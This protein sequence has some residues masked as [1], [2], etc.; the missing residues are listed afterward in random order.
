MITFFISLALLVLGYFIY[1]KWVDK[2]YGSDDAHSTPAVRLKDD[3]DYVPM[4]TWKVFLI[5][6]LNIAGLGPIFGA[7]AGAMWGPVAFLWIVFGSIFIGGVHDYF[8]GMLSLRHDG[9]SLSEVLGKYLGVN[10]QMV[11][12]VVTVVLL[13]LVG[14][15][16]VKG[17]ASILDGLTEMDANIWVIII[18]IYYILATLLP[19]DKVIGKIYPAFGVVLLLMA[20]GIFISMVIK[21]VPIPELTSGNLVNMHAN[22]EQ[23][24][25][26]PMLFITIACG[27]V[28]GFHATQSPMMARCIK[29][30]SS[31][32]K[33]FFGAMITEGIVAL[34]WAAISMSFFGGVRELGETMAAQGGDAAW[35]VN[36][37]CNGMLGRVG[38][39]IAIIGVVV[40]PITSGDTAFRSVRLNIADIVK[41]S[42]QQI[43]NRFYIIIP[44][45]A[46]AIALTFI[47]F[48]IVW[49]YFGWTNQLLATITLWGATVFLSR[50]S[51]PYIVTLIPA[52]F[53]TAVVS[54]YILVA[55]EGLRL[56][57][58]LSAAIGI[59]TSV[60]LALLFVLRELRR[61]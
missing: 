60:V 42:Q 33:V 32:R 14:V 54:T 49:R 39:I 44:T 24:P 27:A 23:F 6:F 21:D 55:P 12:R 53:M 26:F 47:D 41:L 7:I 28:S 13:I 15:V 3:V 10:M 40:A 57:Y 34:I 58:N 56:P 25:I 16:F 2:M 11:V 17:P 4:K 35:V 37:V 38:G 29:N 22:S 46:V 1:S 5:Q 59:A 48:G 20:V 19:V 30:E 52:I 45:F 61:K 36:E 9:S 8:S 50:A 51:K 43:K 31:G 18:F